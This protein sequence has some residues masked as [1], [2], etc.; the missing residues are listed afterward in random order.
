MN[1]AAGNV[2]QTLGGMALLYF[3]AEWLVRGGAGLAQRLG[4]SPLIVG[5]TIVAYGTS[6]PEVIVGIQAGW[7]GHGDLALG[8]VIGSNIAN[9]G[10]ILGL[11]ALL[12]PAPV[13]RA[14]PRCEVPVLLL[15]TLALVWMLQDGRL[16]SWESYALLATSG[17]YSLWMILRT[18]RD[19]ETEVHL[20]A[21]ADAAERVGAPRGGPIPRLVA[22][23][24][25]GLLLLILGGQM[26]VFG[27]S[28][29]AQAMGISERLVGLTIVA[30]GTS[31][32]ELATSLVAAWRGHT[33]MAVGN[34]VG[35][36][37]FN[38]LLCLGAA[39]LGGRLTSVPTLRNPDL[40][41]LVLMTLTGVLLL[42]TERTIRRWEGGALLGLYFLYL[43]IAVARG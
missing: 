29:L 30:V 40:G 2:L 22:L 37:I 13:H 7:S 9:L 38:V 32:P 24:L 1:S 42:R 18:R 12:R 41:A 17:L 19:Q 20:E 15:T 36:N 26:L 14:L 31:I 5:L 39:G 6:T 16:S 28:R 21:T 11:T 4:I 3:G 27:A 25:V 10:L 35:S 33:D 8:N 34:V 23:I 43:G